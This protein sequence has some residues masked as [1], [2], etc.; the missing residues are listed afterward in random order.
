MSKNYW[1]QFI[2]T[3]DGNLI[4]EIT[5]AQAAEEARL[6]KMIVKQEDNFILPQDDINNQINVNENLDEAII[7]ESKYVID[8]TELEDFQAANFPNDADVDLTDV[9]SEYLMYTYQ[10]EADSFTF[11]YKEDINSFIVYLF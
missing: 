8:K 1:E 6:Q 9:I 10:I 7:T 11:E 5:Q 4:S 2:D 3:Y